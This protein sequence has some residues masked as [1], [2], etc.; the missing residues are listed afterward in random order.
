MSGY[1][2]PPLG[3]CPRTIRDIERLQDLSRA[4]G[5]YL[6]EGRVIAPA[7]IEEYNELVTRY[8]DPYPLDKEDK[9]EHDQ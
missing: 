5:A 7:W 3:V 8:A 1:R 6:E 4:I 9:N 2:K